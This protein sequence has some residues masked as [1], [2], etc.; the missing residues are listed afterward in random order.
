MGILYQFNINMTSISVE[1]MTSIY[2]QEWMKTVILMLSWHQVPTGFENG[3]FFFSPVKRKR[4][5]KIDLPVWVSCKHKMHVEEGRRKSVA[6]FRCPMMF[7]KCTGRHTGRRNMR[8]FWPKTIWWCSFI[9]STGLKDALSRSL[10]TVCVIAISLYLGLHG[11]ALGTS[12][13]LIL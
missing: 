7:E 3:I 5:K 2:V 9:A 1:G 6:R 8:A 11:D 4:K 12:P 10:V 13:K